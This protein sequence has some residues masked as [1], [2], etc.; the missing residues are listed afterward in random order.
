MT[1]GA[2]IHTTEGLNMSVTRRIKPPALPTLEM[3]MLK[4]DSSVNMS[5]VDPVVGQKGEVFPTHS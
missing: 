3:Q 5:E 4:V 2:T 1:T